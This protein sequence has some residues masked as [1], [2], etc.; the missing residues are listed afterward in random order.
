MNPEEHEVTRRSTERMADFQ[1]E[2]RET[3]QDVSYLNVIN[4]VRCENYVI[5]LSDLKQKQHVRNVAPLS[6]NDCRLEVLSETENKKEVKIEPEIKMME[7]L[8]TP[9]RSNGGTSTSPINIHHSIDTRNLLSRLLLNAEGKNRASFAGLAAQHKDAMFMLNASVAIRSKSVGAQPSVVPGDQTRS[10][11]NR[12]QLRLADDDSPS[13]GDRSPSIKRTRDRRT[14]VIQK[15]EGMNVAISEIMNMQKIKEWIVNRKT[16]DLL[17]CHLIKFTAFL[18][19]RSFK[20]IMEAGTIPAPMKK[21]PSVVRKRASKKFHTK[22]DKQGEKRGVSFSGVS[23][24]VIGDKSEELGLLSKAERAKDNMFQSHTVTNMEISKRLNAYV[25]IAVFLACISDMQDQA[26]KLLFYDAKLMKDM[27]SKD[28][29]SLLQNEIFLRKLVSVIVEFDEYRVFDCLLQHLKNWDKMFNESI[30]NVF[31]IQDRIYY[32]K[33]FLDK[34]NTFLA[35]QA[36]NG[37][38]TGSRRS[39]SSNLAARSADRLFSSDTKE[40]EKEKDNFFGVTSID[41]TK[42]LLIINKYF[43]H[44]QS[45]TLILD[46]LHNLAYEP[47]EIVDLLMCSQDEDRLMQILQENPNLLEH[48][49]PREVA[50]KRMYKL[51]MIFDPMNLINAF[52]V[53]LIKD[54][55]SSPTVYDEL[56]SNIKSGF[57]IQSLCF[58]IMH[59]S[60]TFWDFDKLWKF[61]QVINEMLRYKQNNNWLA[62]VDNPLLFCMKLANFLKAIDRLL[63]I[64]SKDIHKLCEDLVHFC[65]CYIQHSNEENLRLIFFTKDSEEKDFLEYA[66]TV[67]H[68]EFFEID[69]VTKTIYSQWDVNRHSKQSLIDFLKLH[70]FRKEKEIN[71]ST[72]KK[73]FS[74]P[75]EKDDTFQLEYYL[76]TRSVYLKVVAEIAWPYLLICAEF[77][78][79]MKIIQMYLKN[80][81]TEFARQWLWI[82]HYYNDLRIFS[83][84]HAF[85]RISYILSIIIKALVIRGVSRKGFYAKNFYYLLILLFIL[86]M[87]VYPFFFYQNFW[88]LSN[89]QMLIVLTMIGYSFYL[90]L[91]L[92]YTGVILRIFARMVYVVILFGIT[93]IVVITIV[94]YPIHTIFIGFTQ[95]NPT[96]LNMFR[97]LY[98]GVLTLFEFTFG[99]VVFVRPYHEQ[100]AYTYGM[101]LIMVIFSFFGNIMLANMLVAFLANQFE[102]ITQKAKYYTLRMQFSLIKTVQQPDLDSI[103]TLPFFLT[104]PC[105]PIF[106][107]LARRGPS[108]RKANKLLKK[109]SH[110]TNTVL[111][112]L[113]YYIVYLL[114][115]ALL[116]YV[117]MSLLLLGKSIVRPKNIVVFP[118]WVIFGPLF[119]LKLY[120]QDICFILKITLDFKDTEEDNLSLIS[121]TDKERE[122]LVRPF[123][124]IY[125]VAKR[126]SQ[127][128]PKPII[129]INELMFEIGKSY[130]EDFN[131]RRSHNHKQQQGTE[132]DA[133]QVKE[134]LQAVFNKAKYMFLRKYNPE[135]GKKFYK[136]ILSKFVSYEDRVSNG[137][138]NSMEIDLLFLLEKF[139][140]N[141]S[142]DDI[143]NLISFDKSNLELS[144]KEMGSDEDAQIKTEIGIIQQDLDTLSN[145]I[146]N[147][148]KHL[149]S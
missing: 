38:K 138:S 100:N 32:I 59:V 20:G 122:K 99:A 121:L 145:N 68:L 119:L 79:S 123:E 58:V 42:M 17:E 76:S 141:L 75:I 73:N 140:N 22:Y 15:E 40:K 114:L 3:N 94:A 6:M 29:D 82:E 117:E 146:T 110:V 19:N 37:R 56:C 111:P 96:E 85:L 28:L 51:F 106:F 46:I 33:T 103:F 39:I 12:V 80:E 86:Q 124:K 136:T 104:I 70:I 102:V 41:K 101:T 105:L 113:V 143:H 125:V 44:I 89:L 137:N 8:V 88:L 107:C 24:M 93:S 69:F 55:A 25:P 74:M 108:R 65:I 120:I 78:F 57:K 47:K 71:F 10:K 147:L 142:V 64:N 26:V 5:S 63:D 62:Y 52:N 9:R 27:N 92:D 90:G 98:N 31:L 61:Y 135:D 128:L 132:E 43:E 116:R 115:V 23:A 112:W 50:V 48:V 16:I 49:H 118:V 4:T 81:E 126:L 13:G 2:M 67:K 72:F 14:S 34:F 18:N 60:M 45:N 11:G 53:P 129:N 66:F 84:V 144:R 134:E 36:G 21:A 130:P 131:S 87:A 35:T 77:I 83:F 1:P 95:S 7:S 97:S 54:K 91:S 109:L 148:I 149:A 127:S 133:N 139:K 30:I